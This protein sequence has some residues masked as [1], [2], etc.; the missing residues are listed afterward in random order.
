MKPNK[1][2]YLLPSAPVTLR[3][4]PRAAWLLR[5]GNEEQEERARRCRQAWAAAMWLWQA[6]GGLGSR[7]NRGFGSV[8]LG[9]PLGDWAGA[10]GA[11]DL[12]Q[13]PDATA[14]ARAAAANL[15]LLRG[16]GW[17]GIWAPSSPV[18]HPRLDGSSRI[19]IGTK[20]HRT[21]DEALNEAG[22]V[23]QRGFTGGGRLRRNPDY[24]DVKA[25]LVAHGA[26][27]PAAPPPARLTQAPERS[28]FG[29]PL[30]FRYRSLAGDQAVFEPE[31][32]DRW[33]SPL[34]ISATRLGDGIHLVYCLLSAPVPG[35]VRVTTGSGPTKRRAVIAPPAT[36]ILS[37]FMDYVADPARGVKVL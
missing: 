24:T 11:L 19:A 5:P 30:A 32:G 35:N 31:G 36:G 7:A 23:M 27:G 25:H 28:A 3:V 37:V 8:D 29:L 34:R 21:W 33:P 16:A 17:F 4:V 14:W 26:C 12:R 13:A 9:W 15:Q 18:E 6:F 2:K 22:T 1:R 10:E 20:A